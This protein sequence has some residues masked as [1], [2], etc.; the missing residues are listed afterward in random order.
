MCA[1]SPASEGGCICCFVPETLHS[2]KDCCLWSTFTLMKVLKQKFRHDPARST[3]SPQSNT[4]MR[5]KVTSNL[6][7]LSVQALFLQEVT[8]RLFSLF[9]VIQFYFPLISN[10]H[11]NEAA[12]NS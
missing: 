8:F 6:F 4:F 12:A 2:Y 9:Q 1:A 5:N 11:F 7:S 10:K 3:D